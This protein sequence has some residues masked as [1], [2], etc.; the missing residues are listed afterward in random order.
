MQGMTPSFKKHSN[1]VVCTIE[2]VLGFVTACQWSVQLRGRGVSSKKLRQIY[3]KVSF[4]E[5]CDNYTLGT[6]MSRGVNYSN[7]ITLLK[8]ACLSSVITM[9]TLYM[10]GYI[11]AV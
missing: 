6:Y 8:G 3:S 9:G 2:C 1:F 4:T 5:I 11:L 7:T 10:L